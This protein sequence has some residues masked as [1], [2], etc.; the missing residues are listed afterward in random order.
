VDEPDE[1]EQTPG[2]TTNDPDVVET[3]Q[4]RVDG[5]QEASPIRVIKAKALCLFQGLLLLIL[6]IG[7]LPNFHPA[8]KALREMLDPLIDA[9][10]LWQGQWE[11]FAPDPDSINVR[12]VA[13][14]EFEDGETAQ[15][16]SPEWQ[17]MSVAAKF[18]HFRM[19]EYV[20]GIR[21]DPNRGAWPA[22]ANWVA[23]QVNH[24]QGRDSDRVRVELWRHWVVIPPPGS[25][26]PPLSPPLPMREEY[27]FY[28]QGLAP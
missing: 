9:L 2:S 1:T 21:K 22:L 3:T 16:R 4:A 28:E 11:L 27:K 15:W 26:L 12:V 10:G 24:P 20:D 13:V 18:R 17:E 23:R 19:A 5:N 25:P 6:L 8:Q 7:G 14:V